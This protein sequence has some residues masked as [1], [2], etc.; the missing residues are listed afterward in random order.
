MLSVL[1]YSLPRRLLSRLFQ[2]YAKPKIGRTDSARVLGFDLII[3]PSVFHP[4]LY[5]SSKI[6]GRF[7]STM[8]L[9]G[10]RFLDMGCG[11]GIIG[12][13]AAQANASVVAVDL[14][15]NAVAAT[16]LNA[17]QNNLAH[18]IQVLE[19]DLF[20]PLPHASSFDYIAWNP[21][22]YPKP[23]TGH[24]S[25]AWDA[26]RDYKVIKAFAR[27]SRTFLAPG[28]LV[29]LVLS[30]DIDETRIVNYFREQGFVSRQCS[31]HRRFFETLTI[32][33][34]RLL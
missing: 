21:P 20:Q 8:S 14:N 16:Q 3:P 6:L 5:F 27:Q 31:S 12:L 24:Q 17:Q 10:K 7:V 29:L 2:L 22:F 25:L 19:G 30:S 33:E 26:G 4:S 28:G 1:P 9:S 34:L 23:Q 32:H 11:S 15:P 18:R 13:C